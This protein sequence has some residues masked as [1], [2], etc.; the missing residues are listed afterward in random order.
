[1][2]TVTNSSDTHGAEHD[3]DLYSRMHMVIV[4]VISATAANAFTARDK[5]CNPGGKIDRL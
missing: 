5:Y 1:M 4:R 2:S 3:R